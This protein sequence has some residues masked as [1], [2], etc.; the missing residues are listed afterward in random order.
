MIASGGGPGEEH[1]RQN[2]RSYDLFGVARPAAV[3]DG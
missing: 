3:I 2:Y 1:Y